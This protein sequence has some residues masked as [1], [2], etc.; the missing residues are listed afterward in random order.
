[1]AKKNILREWEKLRDNF[2]KDNHPN[3]NLIR[4]INKRIEY[5]RKLKEV[6]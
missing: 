2:K 3:K 5:L 4:K 6:K 1:M